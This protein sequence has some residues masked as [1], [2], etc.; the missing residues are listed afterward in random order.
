MPDIFDKLQPIVERYQALESEMGLPEVAADYARL[1]EL[2]R[3]RSSLEELVDIDQKYRRLAEEFQDLRALVSE[4]GDPEI[5][6]MAQTELDEVEDQIAALS[7]QLKLALLPRNPNDERNVIVEIHSAAGG[8]EASLF[9]GDLYRMYQRY[10]QEKGW[11]VEIMDSN[12]S[13]LGGFNRIAFSVDGKNAYSNLKYEAGVHRVQRVPETEAQGRIHTS[14][15]TVAVLP[16]A[17]EVEVNIG[18]D[19]LRID[20]F[21]AGGHGG[22]NVNKVATAVRIVHEPTGLVV[23][24]QDERSQ[25]KNKSKAMT[26]LRSR[27]YAAEQDRQQAA[28]SSNR[29]AQIGSGDRSE[30]IRTYN[31][32]QDRVTDHRIGA[33]IHG[34]Q[35]I[36]DGGLKDLID[37]IIVHDQA[38]RLEEESP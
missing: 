14:T 2:N 32:P 38:R 8:Q 10:A 7:D 11:G 1:R 31:Y 20:I 28:I 13:D 25:Y 18:E 6:E 24:C 34:M 4:G 29:K 37:Q 23:V 5:V 15:A 19:D 3:E 36:M 17:D 27:L 12:P 22:Q 33:S 35:R 9:A 16:Q 30:K 21:H 26:I